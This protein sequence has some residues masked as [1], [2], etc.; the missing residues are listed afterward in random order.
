MLNTLGILHLALQCV[1][2]Q[3]L[4]L[5]QNTLTLGTGEVPALLMFIGYS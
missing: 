2:S 5:T 1:I 3:C 4:K